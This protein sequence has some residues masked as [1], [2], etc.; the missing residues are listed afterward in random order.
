MTNIGWIALF[1]AGLLEVGCGLGLKYSDGFTRPGPSI[2]TAAVMMISIA[3]LAFSLK[4]VPLGTAYA[5]WTGIGA[6]GTVILGITLFGEPADLVRVGCVVLI[7][8][9]MIGLRVASAQ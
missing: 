4:S 2:A 7:V 8:I 1:A 5:I 6:V 9:G 3:L